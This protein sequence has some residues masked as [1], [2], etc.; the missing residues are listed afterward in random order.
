[1]RQLE[2]VIVK[3][4][5]LTGKPANRR[6]FLLKK[7]QEP[8]VS[9]PTESNL[10]APPSEVLDAVRAVALAKGENA[11]ASDALEAVAHLVY[12]NPHLTLQDLMAVGQA[13]QVEDVTKAAKKKDEPDAEAEE[14]GYDD[15]SEQDPSDDDDG[16]GD[17]EDEAP[18]GKKGKKM[19]AFLK[20]KLAKTA[21]TPATE[22]AA[23]EAGTGG[24][25]AA[26]KSE[27]AI[28]KSQ[29]DSIR[30]ELAKSEARIAAFEHKEA[31]A[32][33]KS[34]NLANYGELTIDQ[35]KL[36]KSMVALRKSAPE[37]VEVIEELFKAANAQVRAAK[38]AGGDIFARKSSNGF[39]APVTASADKFRA[40][41]EEHVAK[42]GGSRAQAIAAIAKTKDGIAV[43][44][45]M[46][47][48]N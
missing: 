47:G 9:D 2:D 32:I 4:I 28:S 34:A 14:E 16:D 48:A 43:Y 17:E 35:D 29:Y 3:G 42:S 31:V 21:A 46:Q 18:K 15:E 6:P 44:K 40:M 38:S 30:E 25:M 5:A 19:P 23:E 36:A 39:A 26:E 27:V 8:S 10:Q 41:V 11:Q 20:E 1:M 22:N 33:E 13:A 12:S 24:P 7:S 37:H 45:E